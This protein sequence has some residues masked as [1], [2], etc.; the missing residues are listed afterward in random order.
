MKIEDAIK[1]P[2]R[3]KSKKERRTQLCRGFRKSYCSS[4]SCQGCNTRPAENEKAVESKAVAKKTAVIWKDE[5]ALEDEKPIP[6]GRAARFSANMFSKL[7]SGGSAKVGTAD[8]I[9]QV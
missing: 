5:D 1:M 7:V 2:S 4:S 9:G 8:A 6:V 3:N